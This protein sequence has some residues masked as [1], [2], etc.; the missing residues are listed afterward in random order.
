MHSTELLQLRQPIHVNQQNL[1]E[2]LCSAFKVHFTELC[3][4]YMDV[5]IESDAHRFISAVIV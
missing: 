5:W 3:V 4:L 1:A 2:L